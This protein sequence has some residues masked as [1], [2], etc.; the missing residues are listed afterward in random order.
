MANATYRAESARNNPNIQLQP[1]F[2]TFNRTTIASAVEVLIAVLDTMDGDP[3]FEE[4]PDLEPE[5]DRCEAGDDGC[6]AF[7]RH[8]QVYW[9][10]IENESHEHPRY[11]E[12]QS[13]GPLS[14]WEPKQ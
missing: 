2:A 10:S 7:V 9:G 11:G 8:G 4:E 6:G 5:D 12:D 14:P 3:D 1:L 13:K